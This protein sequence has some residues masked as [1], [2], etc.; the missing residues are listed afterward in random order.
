MTVRTLIVDDTAAMQALIRRQL[1]ADPGI[2]V[3]GTASNTDEARAG[4]KALDPDVGTLDVEMLGINGIDFLERLM[5]LRP[6]PV[7]MLS[8]LTSDGAEAS[9]AAL[10]LG[11]FDR[12]DESQLRS[13]AGAAPTGDLAALVRSAARSGACRSARVGPRMAAPA[14]TSDTRPW[15][16][17][18]DRRVDGRRGALIVL[19]AEFPANCPPTVVVQHMPATFTPSFAARLDRLCRPAVEQAR[20]GAPFAPGKVYL[21]PGGDR[22]LEI[23]GCGERR[24]C[25]PVDPGKINGHRPSVNR[26]FHSVA[27][28]AG[29]DAAGAILTGMGH[30]GA[31]GLKAMRVAGAMTFG[32]DQATSVVHGMPAVPHEIG[33]FGE[34]LPLRRIAGRPL[35]ECRA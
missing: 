15:A 31:A 9:L 22:H 8:L 6:T 7:V 35:A 14:P 10:E 21:A 32:Q 17:D 2:E 11:A 19:L 33:A 20:T 25:R 1:S 26:L 5:R 28:I 4:I 27:R 13:A 30:D 3:L 34:H 16:H 24:Y 29:P 18:R 23:A 12:Y